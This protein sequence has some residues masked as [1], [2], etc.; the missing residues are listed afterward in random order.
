MVLDEEGYQPPH[1]AGSV[2]DALALLDQRLFKLVLTDL[3]ADTPDNALMS[4]APVRERA[5]PIPVG[6][7]SGWPLEPTLVAAHG[8]DFLVRK[9]FDIDDLLASI[10]EAVGAPLEPQDDSRVATVRRYFDALTVRDW[11]ELVALCTDDVTYVLPGSG[12]FS[13]EVQGR[14]AF[15]AYTEE[16]FRQFPAARFEQVSVY[17]APHGLAARFEGRWTTGN[18]GEQQQ[19]GSVNFQ[20]AGD[21]IRQIGVRLNDER[22]GVLMASA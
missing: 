8:F 2:A 19:S 22:L 16:T 21:L 11:D 1:V 3:F 9:P 20:F 13:R 18:L 14:A 7:V 5:H 6:V 10:A 17:A 12:P 15:R 4:V